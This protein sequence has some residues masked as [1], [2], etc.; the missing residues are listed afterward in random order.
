MKH[1]SIYQQ[2][3][4]LQC[5]GHQVYICESP[6]SCVARKS[7]SRG[8]Q[9]FDAHH[10]LQMIRC[11]TS[12]L[13]SWR[14]SHVKKGIGNRTSIGGLLSLLFTKCT[15]SGRPWLSLHAVWFCRHRQVRVFPDYL[16]IFHLYPLMTHNVA[17]Y[18][19]RQAQLKNCLR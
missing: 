10:R 19:S 3:C 12:I 4:A 5:S 13:I 8:I 14:S 1:C 15:L 9:S 6:H 2:A 17:V 11:P 16:G 18:E 7:G